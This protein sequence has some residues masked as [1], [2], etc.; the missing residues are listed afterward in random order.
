MKIV[1]IHVHFRPIIEARGSSIPSEGQIV[2]KPSQTWILT[3]CLNNEELILYFVRS[4]QRRGLEAHRTSWKIVK[5]SVQVRIS[6]ISTC[7]HLAL[8]TRSLPFKKV[9]GSCSTAQ[10]L[11]VSRSANSTNL[12]SLIFLANL[13][14]IGA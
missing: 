8:D 1:Q 9:C 10:R 11:T 13:A 14:G 5:A 12:P 2:F 6:L 3:G 7:L 4:N